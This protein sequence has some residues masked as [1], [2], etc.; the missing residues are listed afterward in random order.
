MT[1]DALLALVQTIRDDQVNLRDN[2]LA[3]IQDDV[4]DIKLRVADIEHR[5]TP[6]EEL[7]ALFKAHL[8]KISGVIF[9]G[10]AVW[11]GLPATI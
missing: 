3:H 1:D 2:H 9:A 4:T 6:L 5:L 8:L 11:L 10:L 7:N